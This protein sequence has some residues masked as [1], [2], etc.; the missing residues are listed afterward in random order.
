MGDMRPL[1]VLKRPKDEEIG[2]NN[3]L[4]FESANS[5][6]EVKTSSN[7]AMGYFNRAKTCIIP[8]SKDVEGAKMDALSSGP[9]FTLSYHVDEQNDMRCYLYFTGQCARFLPEDIVL[10]LPLIFG[11]SDANRAFK[12]SDD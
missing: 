5:C 7:S 11:D 6:N 4:I 2:D 10:V 8:D 3:A 9:H 12:E 1:K